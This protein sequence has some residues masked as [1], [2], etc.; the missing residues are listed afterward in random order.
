[1]TTEWVLE[2]ASQ[3]RAFFVNDEHTRTHPL[4]G[5]WIRDTSCTGA[6]GTIKPHHIATDLK[7]DVTTT[8]C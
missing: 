4:Q 1:M 7:A 2:S 5:Y 8:F 6:E 3:A